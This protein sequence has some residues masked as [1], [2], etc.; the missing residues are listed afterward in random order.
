M[1]GFHLAV[2]TAF[3]LGLLASISPCPLATNIAA[4]TYMGRQVA[5]PRRAFATSVAYTLGR[6]LAYVAVASI[7]VA[8]LLSVP[9]LANLLQKYMNRALGPVLIVAGLFLFGLFNLS[10][11]GGVDPEHARRL[12]EKGG[13]AGALTLGFLFA[14]AFCPVSAAL[15]FGSLVP[16][17]MKFQSP[18]LCPS[19]FAIGT[20]VPVIGFGIVVAWGAGAIGRV[21]TAMTK[22]ERFMRIATGVIFLGVGAYYILI[23][24][25]NWI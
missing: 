24:N 6:T 11:P 15:F 20:A 19:A 25:L 1:E 7:L 2:G 13:L 17:A 5:S 3:W 23:F 16:L 8:G 12:A 14:L 4:V 18:L 21:F 22:V 9:K 10:L